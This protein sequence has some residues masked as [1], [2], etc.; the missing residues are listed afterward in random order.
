MGEATD[1]VE[2]DVEE[3]ASHRKQRPGE[4]PQGVV[5][6]GLAAA[7]REAQYHPKAARERLR[8]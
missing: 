4:V 2:M 6:R 8:L 5:E 1:V 3:A 7:A